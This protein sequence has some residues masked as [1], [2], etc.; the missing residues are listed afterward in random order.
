MNIF[1]N[2]RREKASLAS[3]KRKNIR[4]SKNEL[5]DFLKKGK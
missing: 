3:R 2:K 4:I 5:I 1:L